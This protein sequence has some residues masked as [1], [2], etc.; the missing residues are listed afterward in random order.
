MQFA[1]YN[2]EQ[3]TK[4]L[5]K[6]KGKEVSGSSSGSLMDLEEALNR[7]QAEKLNSKIN[8]YNLEG[9]ELNTLEEEINKADQRKGDPNSAEIALQ[10]S[11][12]DLHA[13][14]CQQS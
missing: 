3:Y 14:A 10:K 7:E 13:Q 12:P 8:C 6:N 2:Q 1:L 5:E 9:Q 4:L 11:R